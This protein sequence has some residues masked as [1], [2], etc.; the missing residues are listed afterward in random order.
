MAP[1]RKARKAAKAAKPT[2]IILAGA[3]KG[4]A[5]QPQAATAGVAQQVS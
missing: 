4:A 3:P 5:A 2:K 1:S